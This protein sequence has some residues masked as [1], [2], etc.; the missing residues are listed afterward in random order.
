MAISGTTV[1]NAVS[2]VND[3]EARWVPEYE[4][5]S[6]IITHEQFGFLALLGDGDQPEV[7][8]QYG[9][10][11]M[12]APKGLIKSE[13]VRSMK[14]KIQDFGVLE[15][16]F[17]ANGAVGALTAATNT[18]LTLDSTAGLKP[19]DLIE[20]ASTGAVYQVMS[21]TSATVVV[22]RN[23]TG[24][25]TAVGTDAIADDDDFDLVGSAFYDGDTFGEGFNQEPVED[26]N[27]IQTQVDEVGH[28]WLREEI[29]VY[30]TKDAGLETD[31]TLAR[32]NHNRKRELAFLFGKRAAN[33]T[34]VSGSTMY[35][36]HG[37]KGWSSREYDVGGSLTWDEWV[38]AV[39]PAIASK[40]GGDFHAMSGNL[41]M[42]ILSVLQ[43][44]LIRTTPA[45]KTWGNKVERIAAPLGEIVL[46]GTQPMNRNGRNGEML[47][48]KPWLLKRR[49][50][51]KYNSA[52]IKDVAL[53]NVMKSVNA[54]M[55]SETLM[56]RNKEH[57][58]TVKNVL[59]GG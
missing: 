48:F 24:G 1:E 19:R 47:L 58:I 15:T 52:F 49:Y 11:A 32:I 17:K 2:L 56:V 9:N 44:D 28:G 50:L 34:T 16:A 42:A 57:I 55:T 59:A 7:E 4:P 41:P 53:R 3:P 31:R 26:Y 33:T 29:D 36:M 10:T 13:V 18:N 23:H 39:H 35:S 6:N 54:Y 46:H 20:N 5:F 12:K 43:R 40:G 8:I 51:G 27:Y 45:D 30:P 14:P 22:V 25:F 21:V 37:L 38:T